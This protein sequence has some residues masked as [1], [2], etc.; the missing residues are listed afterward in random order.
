[1]KHKQENWEKFASLI[2]PPPPHLFDT[3]LHNWIRILSSQ[4][5]Y[6]I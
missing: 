2:P 4:E 6:D 1:M 5:G 3:D